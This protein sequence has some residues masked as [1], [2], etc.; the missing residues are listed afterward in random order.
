MKSTSDKVNEKASISKIAKDLEEQLYYE[1]ED[2]SPG[3]SSRTF[4]RKFVK[5]L[6]LAEIDRDEVKDDR[7][8]YSIDSSMEPAM[9]AM[10][11]ETVRKD[12]MLDKIIRGK[13]DALEIEDVLYFFNN[14]V[15]Y[16][17]GKMDE[18][19]KHAFLYEV[20]KNV[21][22]SMFV[23]LYNM[24]SAILALLGNIK[25]YPYEY[26]L[27]ILQ[28]LEQQ[29]FNR[30]HAQIANNVGDFLKDVLRQRSLMEDI[31]AG[32]EED[33]PDDLQ[34][35][36]SEIDSAVNNFLEEN[37]QLKQELLEELKRE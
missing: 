12:G 1:S 4:E 10:L 2:G 20:D 9:A 37:D 18:E 35:Y 33:L 15:K 28:D 31:G 23:S 11:L 29:V 36:Y 16:V 8:R 6:E 3:V 7:N 21:H 19:E 17:D 22:Y 32:S 13:E 27:T 30:F 5:L 26:Q 25:I 24:Q 34:K 14:L